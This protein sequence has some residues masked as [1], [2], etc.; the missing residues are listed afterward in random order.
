MNI[1]RDFFYANKVEDFVR[2]MKKQRI[3]DIIDIMC[4]RAQKSGV[5]CGKSEIKSWKCNFEAI[6]K[7]LLKSKVAGDAVIAFEYKVPV[8]GRIDCVMFGHGMDNAANMLHIELKQWSNENVSEY[9]SGY[10]FCTD[11]V[12][13]GARQTKYTSHPSAQAHEYQCH[14]ENYVHAF[15]QDH[16]NL[17]GFA[18]CYNYQSNDKNAVLCSDIYAHVTQRF[19]LYCQDQM[20]E[21]TQKLNELIGKGEG[22]VIMNKVV[23][24]KIGTTKR[25]QDAAMNMFDGNSNS[26]EFALI[27]T[28]LDAYNSILGSILKTDKD[29]EKTVVVVKGGPGTG[30]SVI[31]MRLIA[32][33]AKSRKFKH[34]FY[35]TR[36]TS[37]IKGYTEILKNVSYANGNDCNAVD[38]LMKN[39]RIK[40]HYNDECKGES[41][42]D[43][44]I[45]DEAHRIE[46]P[47]NDQSDRSKRNQTHLSQIMNM[48]FSSRVSVFFIDDFQSVKGTEIG[49][50]E[51]IKNYAL[52]YYD[53]IIAENNDYLTGAEGAYH[54]GIPKVKEAVRRA[55][56][57]YQ[58]AL[59]SGDEKKI[60]E[61]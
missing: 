59:T 48:L 36:S 22:E 54:G 2:L 6:H 55:E 27:G 3:D 23:N 32:G 8:G 9:Y 10:T 11:I 7:L 57:N 50:S 39:C 21:F 29:D 35:A 14:L 41:W 25:L 4:V 18:F 17:Y 51:N 43:A 61:W 31:A 52:N 56:A 24:S 60:H 38:L 19:P 53:N 20:D 44:L 12:L 5:S 30:K 15:E 40:P 46:N 37:L 34:V 13:D 33:L 28:Q 45:V 42:I 16:I 47:S 58:K 1:P 26:E 49:T